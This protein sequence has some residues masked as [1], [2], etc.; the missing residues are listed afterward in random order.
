VE[1]LYYFSAYL[2]GNRDRFD[3]VLAMRKMQHMQLL[4]QRTK[5]IDQSSPFHLSICDIRIK[6]GVI[7]A[8]SE[9]LEPEKGELLV[10]EENLCCTPGWLDLLAVSGDPGQEYREDLLSL[11]AAAAAGGYTGVCYMPATHPAI[12][13]KADIEYVLNKT[14]G[15]SVRFYPLGALT[16]NREGIELTEMYD[17][18]EAGAVSF[19]DAD[20]PLSDAGIMLRTLQ[21]VKMFDGTIINVPGDHKVVGNASVN[22]GLMSTRLGMYGIPDVLEEIMVTRDILL[23]EYAQSKVHIA[24]VSCARSVERIRQAK[25]KGIRVTASVTPYH[26]YFDE[27][28]V[29]EYDTGF[30]V[31]PPLRTPADVL[32]LKE[33]VADGTIDAITSFHIPWDT[34][35]KECE[36]ENAA[37]GMATLEACYGA[38]A[39]SLQGV[40]DLEKMVHLFSHGPRAILGLPAR[41]IDVGEIAELTLVFPDLEWTLDANSLRSRAVNNTFTGHP[42]KGKPYAVINRNTFKKV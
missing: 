17:M 15:E 42:L 32:A 31:N 22:E 20:Q 9:K 37:F 34:D 7:S 40:V 19:T 11:A 18:R 41:K 33:G 29:G 38:A 12:Q 8:I 28:A 21:Y 35:A 23:A 30:K 13:S 3:Q 1:F 6:E 26:L 2:P 14:A 27:T 24:A 4:L 39:K 25:K 10:A 16:K 5:I 36:F